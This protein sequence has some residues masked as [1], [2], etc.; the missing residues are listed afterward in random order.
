MSNFAKARLLLAGAVLT[1]CIGCD[2]TTKY[3]ATSTLQGELPRSYLA[4]TIRLHYVQNPGGF[5]GAGGSL[6][7]RLRFWLF[8]VMNCS[9][10]GGVGFVLVKHW[11]MKRSTFLLL[12]LILAGGIGNLI[13]R[14]LYD[15]L[16]TDFLNVGVGPLRTG[17]FNVAD[18]AVMGSSIGLLLLFREEKHFAAQEEAA[19]D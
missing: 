11:S 2:Q 15:G 12:L 14:V 9:L 19:G 13:D 16:V 8:T 4:D 5:L 7:P 17:I 3:I 6:S 10:L 18:M 1:G